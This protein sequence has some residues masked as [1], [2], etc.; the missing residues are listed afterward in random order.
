M[1]HKAA[2]LL[3][4]AATALCGCTSETYDSGDG[5]YSYLTA[6]FVVAHTAAS[7]TVDYVVCDSGERLFLSPSYRME[8][9]EKADTAY[10]ALLY[11]NAPK[12]TASSDQTVE[13]VAAMQVPV[14]RPV[15]AFML[16][17][18]A[19]DPLTV[20]SAWLSENGRY[21]NLA[22]LVKTGTPDSGAEGQSI[23]LV[24]DGIETATDGTRCAMTR[25]YH[26][27]GGVPEYYTS[28][29]YVS[30]DTQDFSA[31]AVSIEINT[32]NGKVTKTVSF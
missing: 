10:R 23:G 15:P 3:L 13:A 14:L 21:V 22:L 29:H 11:Y 2:A 1:K 25:L 19:T 5:R 16:E 26:S 8:W 28:R 30:I 12:V 9:A 24:L 31:D 18:V 7:K 27:R 32:Y 4:S 20:E 17:A 6:E